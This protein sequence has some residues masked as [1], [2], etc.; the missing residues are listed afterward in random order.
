MTINLRPF[1]A[2]TRIKGT[3]EA[4][5]ALIM[6]S[7]ALVYSVTLLGTWG[8]VKSWAN[9]SEVGDWQGFLIY[10]GIIWIASLGIFPGIWVFGL[11][12]QAGAWPG[13]TA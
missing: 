9:V 13:H 4:F 3:D 5:K 8:T 10:A 1:C 12:L 7:V 11:C 2:D 6:V